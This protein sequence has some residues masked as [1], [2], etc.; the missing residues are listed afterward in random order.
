[1]SEVAWVESTPIDEDGRH[2]GPRH[3]LV[4][5]EVTMPLMAFVHTH[6]REHVCASVQAS[7]WVCKYAGVRA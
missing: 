4:F 7:G 2:R 1:M 3:H 6:A 5:N